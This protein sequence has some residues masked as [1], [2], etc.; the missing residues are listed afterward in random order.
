MESRKKASASLVRKELDA[1]RKSLGWTPSDIISLLRGG[2][3]SG[4]GS[5]YEREICRQLSL[6]W[7]GGSRDDIFWRSSGSGARAKV[8]GRAGRATAGQHGDVAATDPIGAG[9]IDVFTV[10][11]KRGYSEHTMHDVL[12][13]MPGGGVQE[14][15]RFLAQ[16]IESYMQAGSHTWMLITRRDRRQA[17]VWIPM[18]TYGELRELGAMAI[19]PAPY[20]G[21]RVTVR[22]TAPAPRLA[23]VDVCGITLADW[24]AMVTPAH[25]LRLPHV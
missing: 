13:R 3:S 9:F 22:V 25:V 1:M 23:M 21:L 7:S 18:E 19:R 12:D 4:K 5:S 8:R 16:T 11:I 10:E 20:I 24:V 14:Y 2:G 6:W 17:M 15:E